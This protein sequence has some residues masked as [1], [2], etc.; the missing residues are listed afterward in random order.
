[1]WGS[2][3]EQLL[4]R[5]TSGA[6]VAQALAHQGQL[7]SDGE[8]IASIS[9]FGRAFQQVPSLGE[10]RGGTLFEKQAGQVMQRLPGVPIAFNGPQ[11]CALSC[12]GIVGGLKNS[13]AVM[14]GAP[15]GMIQAKCILQRRFGRFEFRL[16]DVNDGSEQPGFFV[17]WRE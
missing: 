16:H 11:I 8:S 10:A 14:V 5:L 4:C 7:V 1:M 9:Q 2:E 3:L 17:A 6:Y 15:I 13:T 12:C